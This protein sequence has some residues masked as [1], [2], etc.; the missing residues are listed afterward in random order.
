MSEA[1]SGASPPSWARA[2]KNRTT[3]RPGSGYQIELQFGGDGAPLWQRRHRGRGKD[4]SPYR[5]VRHG[6]AQRR[7]I[8]RLP[9]RTLAPAD[10]GQHSPASTE[11]TASRS[12][13]FTRPASG[14]QTIRPRARG[15][16]MS[17]QKSRGVAMPAIIER[18]KGQLHITARQ[19][20][21]CFSGC[22]R[23]TRS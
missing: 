13:L 8:K 23:T 3:A 1:A 16:K 21:V 7:W 17:T 9:I 11:G 15:G 5:Q 12:G 2:N 14:Q 19:K 10:R 6:T 22:P 20:R 18:A 4:R